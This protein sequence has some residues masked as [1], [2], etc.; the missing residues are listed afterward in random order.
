MPGVLLLLLLVA[1]PAARADEA[2]DWT[3]AATCVDRV[4]SLRGRVVAQEDGG[5]F[6]RLYFDRERRDVYLT[7]MRGWLVTW[8]SYVG[9]TIVATGP[10]DRWR[11]HSE[12]ILLTPDA[13]ALLDA[14][15]TPTA[16]PPPSVGAAATATP[17]G[18]VE[19]LRDR[20]RSLERKIQE[21]ESGHPEAP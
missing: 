9:H 20:V 21:L 7:L 1:A 13:I 5:A 12:M 19:E 11:D 3:D 2:V 17:N 10:V 4:C 16:A 14:P 18:E 6:Y 8:P 15:D